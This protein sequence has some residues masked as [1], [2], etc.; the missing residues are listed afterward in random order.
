MAVLGGVQRGDRQNVIT[1]LKICDTEVTGTGRQAHAVNHCIQCTV[2]SVEA[3]AECT[4]TCLY[5]VCCSVWIRNQLDVTFVLSF[6]SLLQVAQHA[7][8]NHVLIFR[9]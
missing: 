6:I 2:G 9:S 5:T 1:N 4:T 8:G 3:D 7:S